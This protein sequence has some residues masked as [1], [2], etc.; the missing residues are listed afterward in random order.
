[1]SPY[2][3]SNAHPTLTASPDYYRRF[4]DR[5]DRDVRAWIERQEKPAMSLVDTA[6]ERSSTEKT[7]LGHARVIGARSLIV[8]GIVGGV[9]G[10]IIGNMA[11]WQ[12][13]HWILSLF[14]SIATFAVVV[15]VGSY[16]TD[17]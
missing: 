9:A 4:P 10:A 11:A 17:K 5:Y 14:I 6:N 8:F 12:H 13:L 7:V 16:L 2:L 1:M 3:N 15:G